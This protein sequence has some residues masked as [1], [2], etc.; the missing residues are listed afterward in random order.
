MFWILLGRSFAIGSWLI[1][2]LLFT[3]STKF[4]VSNAYSFL[5]PPSK[6]LHQ[7]STTSFCGSYQRKVKTAF[8]SL[9][10]VASDLESLTVS[11]LRAQLA[12]FGEKPPTKLK[13]ADLIS[14]L[15]P[16][17]GDNAAALTPLSDSK[18]K[19]AGGP[20]NPD[21][22]QAMTVPQLKDE[23]KSRGLRV[24]G[25]KPELVQ[26]LL[27][28]LAQ[29]STQKEATTSADLQGSDTAIADDAAFTDDASSRS[30]GG[31][32]INGER[33]GT[34]RG[35][36]GADGDLSGPDLMDEEETTQARPWRRSARRPLRRKAEL[37]ICT[38]RP[39]E[40]SRIIVDFSGPFERV[41]VSFSSAP[42]QTRCIHSPS[43]P[44]A[45]VD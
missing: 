19:T 15:A 8:L 31:S 20:L 6:F 40:Q 32:S 35:G 16:Y 14:L 11:D 3:F 27:E 38:G 10:C 33:R 17:V 9:R 43:R 1:T 36:W 22:I 30:E 39:A 26:R 5:S 24:G 28:S 2:F 23:L 4:E 44:A 34:D 45:G 29:P 21:D 18:P 37:P 12:K 7:S 41:R 25:T 42:L 13:K